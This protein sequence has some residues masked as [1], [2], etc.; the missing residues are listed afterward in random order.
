MRL[1]RPW[2][3]NTQEVYFLY[4]EYNDNDVLGTKVHPSICA[5]ETPNSAFDVTKGNIIS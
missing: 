4:L 2:V 1:V 3:I 5:A